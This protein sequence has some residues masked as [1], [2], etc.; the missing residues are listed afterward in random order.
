MIVKPDDDTAIALARFSRS[1]EWPLI[2]TWLLKGREACV[3]GSLS[4][5]DVKSRQ[6]QGA[7][8]AIDELLRITRAAESSV[9]R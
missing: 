1:A 3:Q 9:R 4:P 8:M 5:D 7:L 2:E 6:S